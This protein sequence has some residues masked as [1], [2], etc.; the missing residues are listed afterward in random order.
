VQA[1]I[2]RWHFSSVVVVSDTL[3]RKLTSEVGQTAA[4]SLPKKPALARSRLRGVASGPS[5]KV[6]A[7]VKKLERRLSAWH[8]LIRLL[9]S[10]PSQ[11]R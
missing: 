2:R 7:P 3:A 8:E 10:A 9:V 4:L 6:E 11:S 5:W 1:S